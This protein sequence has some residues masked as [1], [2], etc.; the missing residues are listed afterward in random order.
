MNRA[1]DGRGLDYAIIDHRSAAKGRVGR[2]FLVAV[3][4]DYTN[5]LTCEVTSLCCFDQ[6][7]QCIRHATQ[8]L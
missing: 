3:M 1:S 2:G 5:I 6:V 4:V 7:T 8:A